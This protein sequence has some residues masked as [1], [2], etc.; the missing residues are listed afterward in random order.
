MYY[1]IYKITNINNG[2][3]YIGSHKT[4]DLDDGYFGSGVYLK[5]SIKRYGKDSFIKENILFCDSVEQMLQKET[6]ILQRYKDDVTY[7]LKFCSCGGNT[8][9][10]YTD[11]QKEAYIEK[12]INNPNCPIGK[13]GVHSFNYGKQLQEETRRRQSVTHKARF[14]SLKSN[15]KEWSKWRQKYIPHAL[16][17]QKLMSEI[18]SKPIRITNLITSKTITFKSK[19]ECM[20]YLGIKNFNTIERYA[21]GMCKN[22]SKIFDIL[23]K[24]KVELLYTVKN[25]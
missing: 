19:T 15:T 16:K 7:N 13:K 1:Y 8:R 4:N 6:E 5:R 23:K 3:F 25:K 2:K 10:K 9:E 17:N 22:S 18:N 11:K 20:R 14:A 24:Y 12:L 21:L